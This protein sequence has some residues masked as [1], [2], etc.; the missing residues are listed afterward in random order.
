MFVGAAAEAATYSFDFR[1]GGGRPTVSNADSA[2]WSSKPVGLDVTVI[3]RTYSLSGVNYVAGSTIDVENNN[4]GLISKNCAFEFIVCWASEEHTIDSYG[5]DE[6]MVFTFSEAVNLAGVGIGW[7]EGWGFYDLFFGNSI[8]ALTLLG[9]TED[10]PLALPTGAYTTFAIGTRSLWSG[11]K[12]ESGI[13]IK[14]L[15]VNYEAPAPV[16]LPAA[17]LLP[18]AA[19][20]ALGAMRRRRT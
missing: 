8:N 9:N 14:S 6:S 15:S 3:G 4:Y 16:P 1:T 18:V 13:K 7:S 17:G 2:D 10:G 12:K 20:G 11:F 5:A 19:L